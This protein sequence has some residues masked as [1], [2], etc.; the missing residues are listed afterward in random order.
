M[1]AV[2]GLIVDEPKPGCGST[3]DIS[4]KDIST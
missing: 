1:Q 4:T 3:K 2:I